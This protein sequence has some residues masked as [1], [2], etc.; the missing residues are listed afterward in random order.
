[1]AFQ[2]RGGNRRRRK[3]DFIAANHIDYI[4][5]KDIDLLKRF[6]SERGKILP[7]RVTGT[8]A[9]NQRAL[10][11]AIKRARIMGLMPFVAAD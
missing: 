5:Y 3:V 1:M 11:I 4:D 2:R 8:S 10:T 7:R 6:V 9:K